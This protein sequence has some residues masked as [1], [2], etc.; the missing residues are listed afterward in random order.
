MKCPI[1]LWIV[2]LLALLPVEA[3][4]SQLLNNNWVFGYNSRVNFSSGTPVG[5]T[6]TSIFASEG[7]ASVSDPVSGNLLFYTDGVTVWNAGN[8]VMQNGSGLLGGDPLL[9]SSTAAAVIVPKPQSSTEYYII[10]V[11]DLDG[12][13]AGVTYSLVDMT[14]AGGLGG[15]VAGQ[16][17]ITLY[18]GQSEKLHV[19]PNACNT[20]YWV[21]T[22]G[23]DGNSIAAFEVLSSGINTTPVL[24]TTNAFLNLSGHI[25]VNPQGNKLVVANFFQGGFELYDFNNSTGTVSNPIQVS[26]PFSNSP[27]Y[28]F[29][30]SPDGS[31]LYTAN[32]LQFYQFTISSGNAAAIQ[33]S[34][35]NIPVLNGNPGSVQ[36]GPDDKLYV[37]NG[38]LYRINNPNDAGLACGPFTTISNVG[39]FYGLPQKI[40]ALNTPSLNYSATSFPTSNTA[41]QPPVNTALPGGTYSAVPS[42]L[43]IYSATGNIIPSASQVGT[44]TITYQPPGGCPPVTTVITITSAASPVTCSPNGNWLLFSNYSGGKLNIILDENI[45]NIKIGICT[46]EPVIVNISGQ[47]V[48]NVTSVLYAGL[49][50]QQNNDCGFPIATSSITGV[51]PSL[52]SIV[53]APPVTIISPPNPNNPS[54][55]PNG[56]NAGIITAVSCDVNTWQGGGNTIDQVVDYFQTQFG[57][58]L[59]G[60]K[61]QYCCWSDS[62]PYRS[63][64]VSQSCCASINAGGASMDYPPGPFCAT[65]GNITPVFTG[66]TSGTFYSNPSGLLIN[67]ESGEIDPLTAA[68]GTYEIIYAIPGDCSSPPILLRDTIEIVEELEPELSFSY[69]DTICN[70]QI[71]LAPTLANG[72][73]T[74][75]IFSASSVLNINAANG[76]LGNLSGVAGEFIITYTFSGSGCSAS[77]EF[78][79]T[80]EVQAALPPEFN[81]SYPSVLCAGGGSVLPQFPPGFS[82]TGSYSSTASLLNLN[83]STGEVNLLNTPVG[84][85]QVTF[86]TQAVGCFLSGTYTDTLLVGDAQA[87]V[88]GFSFPDTICNNALVLP[89]TTPGFTA[90]GN[91][92]ANGNLPVN[93]L[94]GAIS[95]Q[96]VNGNFGITYTVSTD[97]CDNGGSFTDSV[98]VKPLNITTIDFSYP[99]ELCLGATTAAPVLAPGHTSGGIFSSPVLQVDSL[100]GLVSNIPQQVGS[101]PVRYRVNNIFCF[102]NREETRTLNVSDTT[103]NIAFSYPDILC[104]N[105]NTLPILSAEFSTGGTFGTY[106]HIDPLTGELNPLLTDTGKHIVTYTFKGSICKRSGLNAYPIEIINCDSAF[107]LRDLFIPEGFT[108]NNDGIND[109]LYVRGSVKTFDFYIYNRWGEQVF[110]TNQQKQ[111]WDGTQRGIML[112]PGV[113]VYYLNGEDYRG[114]QLNQKGNITLIR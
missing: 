14:L 35:V 50:F 13:N 1:Q 44:Y 8:A 42:G 96:G 94:S 26:T 9:L 56:Y 37:L 72:F 66:N 25:K 112:D 68:S 75:G 105:Q 97:G 79:D 101:F 23:I 43:D 61:V 24:S 4:F 46:L 36:M 104:N 65:A 58:S 77:G 7:C 29:E 54:G 52:T 20:G 76:T 103:L 2:F 89:Q 109:I 95:P 111:G 22:A 91:F 99:A 93:P 55:I 100:T 16:K 10:C 49:N 64:E 38:G 53:V 85:Y 92:S 88:V 15:I 83:T 108:P 32:T 74:G 5:S 28:G 110:Y 12:G 98:F 113:F 81:F 3:V 67:A 107:I 106:P 87:P 86:T 6:G 18:A 69:P 57:G 102:T 47:Y 84:T 59:R 30:F 34:A 19:V 31:R 80:I 82:F 51:S 48:G 73:A 39:G 63:S 41:P 70:L 90:G 45:P 40:Y 78:R 17:N 27:W 60:L 11:D 71:N 62:T 114:N 21:L 33:A